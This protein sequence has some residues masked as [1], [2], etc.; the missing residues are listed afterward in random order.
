MDSLDIRYKICSRSLM[1]SKM[2]AFWFSTSSPLLNVF[3]CDSLSQYFILHIEYNLFSINASSYLSSL[4][5]LV[6]LLLCN[7]KF[8]NVCVLTEYMNI[9]AVA[10][11]PVFSLSNL[12]V[13]TMQKNGKIKRFRSRREKSTYRSFQVLIKTMSYF[14]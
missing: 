8:I 4:Y 2:I 11:V 6:K 5:A 9:G 14:I 13:K 1:P 10:P 3:I 12:M 7:I